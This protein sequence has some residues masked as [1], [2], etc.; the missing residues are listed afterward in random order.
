MKVQLLQNKEISRTC[1]KVL[2]IVHLV[3]GSTMLLSRLF[4]FYLISSRIPWSAVK[5]VY[6]NSRISSTETV[7]VC[8][9]L[10]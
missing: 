7:L 9:I 2:P 6:S 4:I 1:K 5:W 8:K 10:K 3:I